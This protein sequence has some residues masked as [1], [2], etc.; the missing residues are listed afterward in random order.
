MLAGGVVILAGLLASQARPINSTSASL[1]QQALSTT[2]ESSGGSSGGGSSGGGF[3]HA[4]QWATLSHTRTRLSARRT[5]GRS[6][7]ES[8]MRT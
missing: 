5:S 3:A 6:I 7:N 8:R 2:S 1:A 4:A